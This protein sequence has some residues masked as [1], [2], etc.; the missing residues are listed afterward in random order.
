MNIQELMEYPTVAQSEPFHKMSKKYGF[1]PTTRPIKILMDAGWNPTAVSEARSRNQK[2]YQKHLIR[3]SNEN[4]VSKEGRPE[5]VMINSHQGSTSFVLMMGYYRFVCANGLIVGSTFESYKIRHLG[6]MD[7][8]VDT[9]ISN[10]MSNTDRLFGQIET[11]REMKVDISF[12][13]NYIKTV[14]EKNKINLKSTDEFLSQRRIEDGTI[15]DRTVWQTMNLTQEK[16]INGIYD[17]V[18]VNN[19][20]RKAR[21]INGI[22]R[23]IKIN[24]DCWDVAENLISLN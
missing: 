16:L 11:F 15:Q 21:K 19:K 24:K 7:E 6:Y 20:K 17:L 3:F 23:I 10:I 9:V 5:I 8:K 22:D 18:D 1:V 13:Q 4:L 12:Q 14:S 2:G